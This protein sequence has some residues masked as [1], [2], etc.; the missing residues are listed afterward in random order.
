MTPHDALIARSGG[1]LARARSTATV[2][3]AVRVDDLAT[4]R[5]PGQASAVFAALAEMAPAC[6][7]EPEALMEVAAEGTGLADFGDASFREPLGVLCAVES[8]NRPADHMLARRLLAKHT[9]LS[10]AQAREPGF[11]LKML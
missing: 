7:L 5:F 4:P 1:D 11:T 3:A 8:V 9:R 6:V 10:P 2:P